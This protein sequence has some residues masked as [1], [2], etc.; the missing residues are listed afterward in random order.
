MQIHSMSVVEP[1]SKMNPQR[2]L[3]MGL[4]ERSA[5][6]KVTDLFKLEP[7]VRAWRQEVIGCP[8]GPLH[9]RRL[10]GEGQGGR[11]DSI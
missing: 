10:P 9:D 1:G 8:E 3:L 7:E 2:Q 6:H 5:G 11:E 4:V